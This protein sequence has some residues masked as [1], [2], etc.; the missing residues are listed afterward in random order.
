L[1]GIKY[2]IIFNG[3]IVDALMERMTPFILLRKIS[4]KQRGSGWRTNLG[5][6]FWEKPYNYYFQ[7]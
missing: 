4:L 7:G 2:S 3:Q 1:N 6:S 5:I